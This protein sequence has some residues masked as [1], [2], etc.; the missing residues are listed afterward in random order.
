MVHPCSQVPMSPC[1]PVPIQNQR[2]YGKLKTLYHQKEKKAIRSSTRQA[3]SFS[4]VPW[5]PIALFV[6]SI[7]PHPY[8]LHPPTNPLSCLVAHPQTTSLRL[9]PLPYIQ[10]HAIRH[11][12]QCILSLFFFRFKWVLKIGRGKQSQIKFKLPPLILV[13][14]SIPWV[15]L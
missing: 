5:F 1:L 4:A 13:H 6:K 10:C 14:P 12:M 15:S 8:L 2:R 9:K 3:P 11:A 7:T